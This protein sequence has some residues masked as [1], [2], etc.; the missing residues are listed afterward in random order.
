MDVLLYFFIGISVAIIGAL[1]L[2]TTN[3]A[4]VNTT[5]KE[6][7]SAALKIIY[8]A[9]LAEIILIIFAIIFNVQIESFISMNIWL[10]YAI[11]A[12]LLIV[13][14]VL[15]SGRAECIKDENGECVI[16]KERGFHV[17][18]QMLGFFLGL[19][20]PTV[21]IYW[22]FVISYLN[23]NIIE[24][25]MALN[26]YIILVFLAG[27]Y[28]G[29]LA[30]LYAYGK[31]SAVLKVRMKNLTTRVNRVIGVLLL[32]ISIVQITKLIYL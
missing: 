24:L 27:S 26:I 30:V 12:I 18:K 16:I 32:S 31:F 3:I 19:I 8:T 9:A 13:S 15:L 17:S 28:L 11:V 6:S 4:V 23:N 25:N 7:V 1:P 14:V 5:I 21:L 20:N 2:G 10:Q 22:I 29:K